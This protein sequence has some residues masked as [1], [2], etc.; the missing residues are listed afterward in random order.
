MSVVTL[1][2]ILATLSGAEREAEAHPALL[3]A[4]VADRQ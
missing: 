3:P 2:E 1:T 4:T